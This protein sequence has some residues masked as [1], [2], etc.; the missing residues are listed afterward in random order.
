[1]SRRFK[2]MSTSIAALLVGS[3]FNGCGLLGGNARILMAI[4]NEELW[5]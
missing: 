1:M 5:G 4:L 3:L 2:M